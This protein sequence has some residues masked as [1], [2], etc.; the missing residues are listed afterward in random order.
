MHLQVDLLFCTFKFRLK[1]LSIFEIWNRPLGRFSYRL[2]Y[3]VG[4]L[5]LP[6]KT[7]KQRM[8]AASSWARAS[9]RIR[10]IM[11]ANWLSGTCTKFRIRYR[12]STLKYLTYTVKHYLIACTK[13]RGEWLGT[14]IKLA[15]RSQETQY[16]AK[17]KSRAPRRRRGAL[18]LSFARYCVITDFHS[19]WNF[20]HSAANTSKYFKV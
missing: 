13:C 9:A 15:R 18:D 20:E 4:T 17:L 3:S 11:I 5:Y 19:F 14:V 8:Y 16:L 6:A 7:R 10:R 2:S 1:E 12:T